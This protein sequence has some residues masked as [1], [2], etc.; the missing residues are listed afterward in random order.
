MLKPKDEKIVLAALLDVEYVGILDHKEYIERC[1][2]CT[3][4]KPLHNQ[5]CI[6]KLAIDLLRKD[7]RL[8][9]GG[10]CRHS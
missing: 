2:V 9:E 5:D 10:L 1:A 3:E 4:T 6:V 8:K 7:L